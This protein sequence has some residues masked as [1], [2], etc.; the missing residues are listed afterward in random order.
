MCKLGDIIVIDKYI[1]DDNIIIGKHSF[2]VISDEANT[3]LGLDYNIV[4]TVI[5]SF[6]SKSHK[7]KKLSYKENFEIPLNSLSKGN[8]KKNR[9]LK[10]ISYS[11]SIKI[12][13]IIMF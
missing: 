3:I 5:S 10:L 9:M 2:I 7:I 13:L 1:G 6:K 4:A 11:I 12:K 8:L